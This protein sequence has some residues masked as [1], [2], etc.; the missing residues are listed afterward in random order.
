MKSRAFRCVLS[1]SLLSVVTCVAAPYRLAAQQSTGS[2]EANDWLTV[3]ECPVLL[4]KTIEVPAIDSGVLESIAIDLNAYVTRGQVLSR[5][6]SGLA[7]MET[8]IAQLQYA[9]ATELASD[10]SNV[11]Y[12]ELALKEAEEELANYKSLGKSVTQTELRRM[13]L[14]VARAE[15]AVQRSQQEKQQA[16][17]DAQLKKAA[18][19][20]SE[21][22]LAR[23]QILSPA[24]GVVTTVFR[25]A[26]EWVEA[27]QPVLKIADLENLQIDCL[28]HIQKIDLRR[29][30]DMTVRVQADQTTGTP[31]RLAGKINS[32]DP[33]VSSQGF[34]RLHAKVQNRQQDGHW[35]LLPGM[36]VRVQIAQGSSVAS[37]IPRVPKTSR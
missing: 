8:R 37:L 32:Y 28:V 30:K 9:S 24:A 22:R 1:I 12:H 4:E 11:K 13:S 16:T 10:Q 17:L 36:T 3:E 35:Q 2:S 23:R 21:M 20:A 15:L 7:K 6:E 18:L 27:G 19:E 5:L 34:V 26:G 31:V 14:A 33:E 29:I 25:H